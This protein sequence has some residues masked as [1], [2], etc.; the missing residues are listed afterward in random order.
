[1]RFLLLPFSWLYGLVMFCRNKAFDLGVL[2]SESV[3]VPVISVGNMTMGGTGKTPLVEYTVQRCLFKDRQVAVVSRGYGRASTGVLVVSDGKSVLANAVQGGDEPVQIAGR[4]PD[5][6]VVVGERRVDAART[7]VTRLNADVIV[8]DDGF[9]HRYL[10][11]NL[12]IVVVDSRRNLLDTPLIPAGERRE[13]LSAM[14]RASCVALSRVDDAEDG[15]TWWGRL[16]EMWQVPTIH[17]RYKVSRVVRAKTNVAL[18]PNE[19]RTK[20]FFLFSGIGDHAGFV[21]QMRREGMHVVGD[22]RFPDHHTFSEEDVKAI[23]KRM[24]DAGADSVL[25]TEKDFV[26]LTAGSALLDVFGAQHPLH[27]AEIAV[28]IVRGKEMF[29]SMIDRCLEGE[30]A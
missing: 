22:M 23:V 19:L 12:D 7:A 21:G 15:Q 20:R 18:P 1:M 11:R 9:Q 6:R 2:R 4:F 17:Y 30:V 5:A 8:L 16:A 13:P 10:R 26:R 25:T 29:D 24:V 27:Y 3:G 28:E 14:R